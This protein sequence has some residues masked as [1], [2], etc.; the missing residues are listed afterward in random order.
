MSKEIGFFL[1]ALLAGANAGLWSGALLWHHVMQKDVWW[2][3]AGGLSIAWGSVIVAV[4]V[5]WA[6]E[7]ALFRLFPR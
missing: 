3:F 2:E 6:V 4:I 7:R 1:I 5:G